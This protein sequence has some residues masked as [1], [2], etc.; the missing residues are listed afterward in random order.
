MTS[1]L[2]LGVEGVE[3]WALDAFGAELEEV[4]PRG[5]VLLPEVAQRPDSVAQKKPNP[6][7]K[8]KIK[9]Y[10]TQVMS[11]LFFISKLV[12]R[13]KHSSL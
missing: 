5:Q 6:S 3:R 9:L 10:V 1:H 8:L 4:H 2:F 7:K 13:K 11:M 12:W